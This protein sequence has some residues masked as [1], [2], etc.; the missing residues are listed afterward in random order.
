MPLFFC[1]S[2]DAFHT[3]YQVRRFRRP[4]QLLLHFLRPAARGAAAFTARMGRTDVFAA[5]LREAYAFTARL[6]EAD[7]FTARLN[8][9][10]AFTARFDEADAFAARPGLRVVLFLEA[11][12]AGARCTRP[13]P[14]L[15]RA[16]RCHTARY[17][18]SCL[19]CSRRC[20]TARYSRDRRCR[21]YPQLGSCSI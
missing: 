6:N 17:P 1:S 20:R 5:R 7:T 16:G 3:F 8:E 21:S 11:E 18:G 10:D 14:L 9:A 4:S 15:S 13:S 2:L 19:S 12:P